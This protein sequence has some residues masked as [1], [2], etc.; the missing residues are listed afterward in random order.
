MINLIPP[1]AHTQVKREYWIRVISVWLV[2]IGTAFLIVA[3]LNLP[4]YV[5][6]RS[7]LSSYLQEYNQASDESESFKASE[8]EIQKSNE[9]A[10]LL[11]KADSVT[12]FSTI[13]TELE[14]LTSSGVKISDFSLSRQNGEISS[15]SI[16]GQA[17][18][19]L[20]LTQFK[21][22]VEASPLFESVTLPLS[23]LA[24]DKDISFSITI[25][26][27]KVTQ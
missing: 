20:A 19:R 18:S 12:P 16:N 10:K 6:V 1:S 27:S 22:A 23:N 21:D 9:I 2:L 13:I 25:V 7:Q 14:A 5:L 24:K 3:L 26:P 17:S 15:I 11:A 4:V 8:F